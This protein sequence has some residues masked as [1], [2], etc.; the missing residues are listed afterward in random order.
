VPEALQSQNSQTLA[1]LAFSLAVSLSTGAVGQHMLSDGPCAALVATSDLSRCWWRA[2]LKAD[3]ELAAKVRHIAEVLSPSERKQLYA[4]Q[5]LWNSY[6]KADC[7]AERGLYGAGTAGPVTYY[8][9]LEA[10]AWER[11]VDLQLTYR[12]RIDKFGKVMQRGKA[13]HQ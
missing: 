10:L 4:A 2:S 7:E 8:A 3:R 9:C 11:V 13:E 12:M 1:L 6:R 5:S